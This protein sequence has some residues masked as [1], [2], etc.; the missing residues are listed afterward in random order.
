MTVSVSVWN[1][2]GTGVNDLH[3]RQPVCSKRGTIRKNS[4]NKSMVTRF[5]NKFASLKTLVSAQRS[6]RKT[7]SISK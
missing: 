4:Q 2:S 6:F 7:I 3:S 5:E 1:G